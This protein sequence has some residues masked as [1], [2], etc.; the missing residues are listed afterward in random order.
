[1]EHGMNTTAREYLDTPAGTLEILADANHVRQIEFV[2]RS[3]QANGNKL[4]R[5]AAKQLKAYFAGKRQQFDLPLAQE[6]T[7]FQQQV[8]QALQ[9]IPYGITCSYSDIAGRI[10]RPKAVRAVGAA[11]GQ[12]KIAIVIPCHRVIGSNGT[13]TGYAGGLDKKEILLKLEGSLLL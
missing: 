9:G 8:W 13:L 2:G 6:G 12:N 10:G 7:D 1:M 11:N 5:E 3:R 4:T